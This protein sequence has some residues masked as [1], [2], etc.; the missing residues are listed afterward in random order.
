MDHDTLKKIH[1]ESGLAVGEDFDKVPEEE[2]EA[3]IKNAMSKIRD[4]VGKTEE[5]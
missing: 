4:L 3:L 2:R 1:E 5:D